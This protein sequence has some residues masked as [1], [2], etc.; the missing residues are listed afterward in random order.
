MGFA[1]A[2]VYRLMSQKDVHA[3]PTAVDA[4]FD[5]VPEGFVLRAVPRFS[6]D[7]EDSYLIGALIGAH[8]VLDILTLLGERIPE[9]GWKDATKR[10]SAELKAIGITA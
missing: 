7:D 4:A 3:K 5:R 9:L 2:F 6:L 8:I 10:V 1:Y